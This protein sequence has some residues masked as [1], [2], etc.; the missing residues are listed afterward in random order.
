MVVVTADAAF[1][2]IGP[3]DFRRQ[4]ANRVST[5][6]EERFRV[7][8]TS[9]STAP[10]VIVADLD[11]GDELEL[12]ALERFMV[13]IGSW[14]PVVAVTRSFEGSVARRL[15]QMRVADFLVKPV[16]PVDLVQHLRTRRQDAGQYRDDRV[17]DLHLP[18]GRRRRRRDNAGGADRD[19]AA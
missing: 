19:A 17:A 18:A 9:T 1:E 11:P 15:M 4:R 16:P 8:I 13:R 3:R 14:P 5:S 6:S 7:R 2:E 10:A 12:Q